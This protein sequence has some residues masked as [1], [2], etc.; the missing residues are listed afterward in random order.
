[1]KLDGSIE[2]D[3]PLSKISYYQIGGPASMLVTPKSWQDLEIISKHIAQT[4]SRFFILGWGSN[5]LFP[6]VGFNGVVIRMKHLFNEIEE[7]QGNI[8]RVGASVGASSL[9]RRAQEK[10]YGNLN[11]LTGIPGSVG[12]MVA[13]NAGTHLGE[14]K[15][16]IVKVEFVKLGES[17]LNLKT[18]LP[19]EK[20]FSYRQNH[21]LGHGDL[22]THVEVC[23]QAEDPKIVKAE[24]DELYQRRK[25][26]Q[27]VDF[28]SCGSV[29]MNPTE[30]QAWKVIDQIGLRGHRIGNAQ[31]AD[32]HSN[33]II[34]LGGAK[35]EDV[36]ALISLAQQRAK[37]QLG[38][39]LHK[40]VKIIE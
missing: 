24:I 5:L 4:Q 9:L 21:F 8:L 7:M 1:M 35:A 17:P 2:Y 31:F 3:F 19:T 22:I 16:L 15:D 10:G 11:R 20:S 12:G 6:D 14:I 39:E 30:M 32:K 38:I 23:Y 27:P 25:Q 26:T 37:D 28:P 29:F 36:K 33:F 13:M 40:E 34:N 18:H